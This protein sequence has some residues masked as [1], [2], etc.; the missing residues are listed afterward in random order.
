MFRR[1]ANGFPTC[2]LISNNL[3]VPNAMRQILDWLMDK[4]IAMVMW[5]YASMGCGVQ[6]VVT[7]GIPKMHKWCV[8]NW[9]M[10]D[11]ST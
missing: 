5:K 1:L 4:I 11:V 7:G 8:D 2:T 3:Q 6:C 9:D 10:M